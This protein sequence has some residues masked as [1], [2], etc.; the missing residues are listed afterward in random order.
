MGCVILFKGK[1]GFREVRSYGFRVHRDEKAGAEK[2][3]T[4]TTKARQTTEEH[5]WVDI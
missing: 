1:G 5:F 4:G 3:K 2:G